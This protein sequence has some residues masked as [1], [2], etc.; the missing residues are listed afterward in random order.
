MEKLKKMSEVLLDTRGELLPDK[1][2]IQKNLGKMNN[3]FLRFLFP[4]LASMLE[5]IL[6]CSIIN[7]PFFS[8]K[9][10]KVLSHFA[11]RTS[12]E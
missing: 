6:F 4:L 1:D 2:E 8:S 12:A 10:W 9:N 7:L 3:N 5:K 11:I